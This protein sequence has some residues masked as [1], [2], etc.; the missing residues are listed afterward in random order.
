[1]RDCPTARSPSLRIA[2]IS[3]D[4]RGGIQPYVA[5]ARGLLAAGHSVRLLAPADFTPFLEA[6]GVPAAPLSGSVEEVLR[7]SGGTAERGSVATIILA[8][9]EMGSRLRVWTREALEACAGC[10]LILGGLG[11]MVVGLAVAERLGIPFVEAHLHPMGEPTADFPGIMLGALP[12]WLGA[13]ARR[14]SHGLT[15]LALWMPMRGVI[16]EVR[17]ELVGNRPPPDRE[18]LPVLYG[19]SAEVV[20]RPAEWHPR[21]AVTGYWTLPAPD[22]WTPPPELEAFLAA[23]PTPVCIGFGSMNSADPVSTGKLVRE[24]VRQAGVRA[25]L[26]SGWG[27]LHDSGGDGVLVTDAVP[28]DWLF[29]RMSA[30]VHHGGA[31]TT[32]AGL[33]A[34][35]PSVLVPFTMDQPFWAGR[36]ETLGVGPAHIPRRRLSVERLAAAL[37]QATTDSGMRARAAAVGARLRSEDGVTRAVALLQQAADEFRLARAS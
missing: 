25:V 9:R 34:G 10:D 28:H 35:A 26:L 18:H 24:A 33:R 11:G 3:L 20:P 17:R 7:Q 13:T 4:T 12:R 5:L 15:Y 6:W 23:G 21:R 31:G 29:P 37:R 14:W 32:A 8:R 2:L 36:V 27:G 30:V 19:F 16:E 22:G 1:M